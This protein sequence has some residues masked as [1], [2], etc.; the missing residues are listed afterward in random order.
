MISF[1]H[2][3]IF[4]HIPKS[5]GTSIENALYSYSDDIIHNGLIKPGRMI[6][7]MARKKKVKLNNYRHLSYDKYKQ[8]LGDDINNFFIFSVLRTPYDRIPSLYYHSNIN[9]VSLTKF[10]GSIVNA[11]HIVP[12]VV[13]EMNMIKTFIGN[14]K[15]IF[16]LRLEDLNKDW[17]ILL[18]KLKLPHINLEHLNP[19][20]IKNYDNLYKDPRLS[21]VMG[22]VFKEELERYF[23]VD[24]VVEK[25][26]V[27]EETVFI[28]KEKEYEYFTIDI[29][30]DITNEIE[31]K[32]YINWEF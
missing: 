24:K 1:K 7:E 26:I 23:S 18:K 28:K 27:V 20:R 21:T 30:E 14:A 31:N 5:A 16:L 11:Y 9:T 10:I 2:K 25:D 12:S 29:I 4:I 13:V 17:N 6:T 15:D 8:I 3:F 19:D 22:E 32:F